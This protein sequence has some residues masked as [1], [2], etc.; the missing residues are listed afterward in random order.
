M[1]LD[2]LF[3]GSLPV[4]LFVVGDNGN[5]GIVKK[6]IPQLRAPP[7]YHDE[8]RALI[9]LVQNV[10]FARLLKNRPAISASNTS[11][12]TLLR[13]ADDITGRS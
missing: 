11:P 5:D 2:N 8:E 4:Y 7:E 10:E 13:F 9:R 12:T 3:S 1:L 6:M